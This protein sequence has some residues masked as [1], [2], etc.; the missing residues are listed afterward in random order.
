MKKERKSAHLAR[1]LQAEVSRQTEEM[2]RIIVERENAIRFLSHDLRKPMR[3]MH[4]LLSTLIARES[5]PE[6]IKMM[7]I[8]EQKLSL[9]ELDLSEVSALLKT[10]HISEAS[11]TVELQ[12]FLTQICE[13]L[14]PD[15]VANGIRLCYSLSRVNAFIKPQAFKSIVTNLIM[16]AV[17][18]ASCDTIVVTLAK[19]NGQCVVTVSDNGVG[20][21]QTASDS[22]LLGTPPTDKEHGLGLYI[23][24]TYA[25]S[26]NG[27]LEYE[28]T[29]G[30]LVFTITL[31]LA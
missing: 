14:S 29:E 15:C 30:E 2:Q 1:N 3:T 11:E 22:E 9:I 8:L 26:M 19:K 20:L 12:E 7:H 10:N 6:Q 28:Y 13:S 25:Q 21:E 4:L 23:C 5:D 16:N 18:H 31:P 27:T 17:E 24:R